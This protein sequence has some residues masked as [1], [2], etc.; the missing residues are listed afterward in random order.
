[1]PIFRIDPGPSRKD[2]LGAKKFVLARLPG[3]FVL[4]NTR[5]RQIGISL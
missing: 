5:L 1:M 2:I 4:Q 3:D